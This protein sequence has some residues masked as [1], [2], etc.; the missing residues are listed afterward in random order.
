MNLEVEFEFVLTATKAG[1]G[2]E[3]KGDRAGWAWRLLLLLCGR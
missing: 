1:E 2:C 3:K